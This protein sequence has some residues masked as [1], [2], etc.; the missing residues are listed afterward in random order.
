MRGRVAGEV[1]VLALALPPLAWA[2]HCDEAWL[3][4][5]WSLDTRMPWMGPSWR[6]GAVAV[7]AALAFVVRPRVGRWVERVGAAEA[8]ASV[9]RMAL[10]LLLA[11]GMTEVV[12]RWKGKPKKH[13][14]AGSADPEMNEPDPRLGWVWKGPFTHT[15]TQWGRTMNLAFDGHHD[16]VR[17]PD[18]V[19]DPARPTVLLVGESIMAGHGLTWDE[20]LAGQLSAALGVQVVTLGVVGY[21][22]DQ[23]FIRLSDALPRF[24]HVVAVVTIFFPFLV[25]RVGWVDR[26]RLSFV[27]D[28]PVVSPPH[29]GFWADLRVVRVVS[30]LLPYRDEASIALTGEIFRQTDRLARGRGARAL[31]VTPQLGHGR[32]RG[33]AYLVDDLLTR[34]G[35]EVVD[36]DWDFEPLAPGDLHPNARA[37]H[38]MAA[39]VVRALGGELR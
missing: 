31:F 20:S 6:G 13:D 15:T 38:T 9:A 2:W 27:A 16:R 10:A 25:D 26:P 21:G 35:L 4:R 32:P 24:E 17:S 30:D 28:S 5:H 1:L 29:P 23:A 8:L 19:E 39:A 34:Q 12:L 22:C 33:D 3:V 37:T 18:D 36:P 11:V 14:L 7:A